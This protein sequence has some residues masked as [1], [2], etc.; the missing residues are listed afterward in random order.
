MV[1]AKQNGSTKG[2]NQKDKAAEKKQNDKPA[3]N[4][5][6]EPPKSESLYP[7]TTE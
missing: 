1:A 5:E 7:T 6:V 4:A 2:M 3:T